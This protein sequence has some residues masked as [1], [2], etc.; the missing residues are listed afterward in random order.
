ML[1]DPGQ[2]ERDLE[3]L[4]YPIAAFYA[5]PHGQMMKHN[6]LY[7][8]MVEGAPAVQAAKFGNHTNTQKAEYTLIQN[9]VAFGEVDGKPVYEPSVPEF[10][11]KRTPPPFHKDADEM[12]EWAVATHK[13]RDVYLPATGGLK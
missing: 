3:A 4:P 8:R 13:H 11:L 6:P 5:D 7:R 9:P 1:S 12:M 2:L 10:L